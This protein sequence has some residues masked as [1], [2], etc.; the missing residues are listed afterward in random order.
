L[1]GPAGPT[2]ATGATGATGPTGAAGS[3]A[4]IPFASGL[5]YPV[6]TLAGGLPGTGV[7]LGFGNG[8]ATS[9]PLGPTI[10][11]TGSPG[12]AV[13]FA[14]SMPRDG[15]ITSISVY[16]SNSV[17]LSLIGTTVTLTGQLYESTTPD[18]TFFPIP[19]AMVTLAPALTG[20]DAIGTVSNGVTTGLAIPVTAQT[21][22]L[23]VGSATAAG[24]SLI[25]TVSGY[26]SAGV[27]IQ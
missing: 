26:W 8:A 23:F 18:N 5:D 17:A 24:L 11:L 16:W 20:I 12:T 7:L 22:V 14:F 13:N 3:G 1:A 10:D 15:T 2:G 6:T 27:S 19:G 9:S 21:R 4:I 25:D